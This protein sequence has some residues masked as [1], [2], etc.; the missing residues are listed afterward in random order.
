M[1]SVS[2]KPFTSQSHHS[3]LQLRIH[4]LLCPE[5]A[6]ITPQRAIIAIYILLLFI[7]LPPIICFSI[8]LL[9]L[10]NNLKIKLCTLTSV[11]S[12]SLFT[13]VHRVLR[14]TS[15]CSSA[16]HSRPVTSSHW[17]Q[18][19]IESV[20]SYDKNIRSRKKSELSTNTGSVNVVLW[21]IMMA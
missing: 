14:V 1:K 12:M 8:R 11:A 3:W 20:N 6:A 17:S 21:L 9:P 4:S 16:G 18:I 2:L 19:L 5:V 7:L 13:S 10:H 15:C